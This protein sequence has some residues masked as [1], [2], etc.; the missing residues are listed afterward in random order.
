MRY[1]TGLF[2]S[3]N[4]EKYVDLI[5]TLTIANVSYRFNANYTFFQPFAK[6]QAPNTHQF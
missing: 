5:K 6:Q 4:A 1:G 2:V 3:S